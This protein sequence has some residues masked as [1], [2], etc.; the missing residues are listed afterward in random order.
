MPSQHEVRARLAAE[1]LA[2]SAWGNGPFDHYPEHRH[3]YDKVLVAATGAITFHL[4]ELGR[5][6]RLDAGDRLDLP[7]GTLH[8]AD[9]GPDGVTCLEAHLVAG[10]LGPLPEHRPGWVASAG[11]EADPAESEVDPAE[12]GADPAVPEAGPSAL[13]ADPSGTG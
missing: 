7:A 12:P 4:P 8:G 5:D 13:Q 1:G 9:V 3:G 6:V 10:S 11:L 2:A